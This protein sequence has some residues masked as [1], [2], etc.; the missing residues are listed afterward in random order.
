MPHD[1]LPLWAKRLRDLREKR[2]NGKSSIRAFAKFLG[3]SRA[4][5]QFWE[6]GL[7]QPERDSI[8]LIA[9]KCHVTPEWVAGDLNAQEHL[10]QQRTSAELEDDVVAWVRCEGMEGTDFPPRIREALAGNITAA[11]VMAEL[12]RLARDLV[13]REKR[14]DDRRRAL[15]IIGESIKT[16]SLIGPRMSMSGPRPPHA[17]AEPSAGGVIEAIA[18][19]SD[20]TRSLEA[21]AK[22][23]S[24]DYFAA[25]EH[26]DEIGR[27]LRTGFAWGHRRGKAKPAARKPAGKRK[28]RAGKSR[29]VKRRTGAKR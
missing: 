18:I 22:P 13:Q 5:V 19:Y 21:N 9:E 28:A 12:R 7:R 26:T 14:L 16:G 25:R 24:E 15:E 29:A 17:S 20:R 23:G 4:I 8:F 1:E 2:P 27:A 3:K 6:K 10:G 11:A